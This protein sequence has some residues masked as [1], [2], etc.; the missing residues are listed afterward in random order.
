VY[1]RESENIIGIILSNDV[2]AK[3]LKKEGE[4]RLKEIMHEPIFI[5]ATRK[6]HEIFYLF[7]NEKLNISIVLDEYGGLAGIVTRE[8]IIEEVLGELYDEN[9]IQGIDRIQ[10][11]GAKSWRIMG[12]TSLHQFSDMFETVIPETEYAGTIA[13]YIVEKLDRIPMPGDEI[14]LGNLNLRIEKTEK[15][16]IVSIVLD[17]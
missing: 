9:E 11:L 10:K 13:G 8:D 7:K 14:R 12:D 2:I 3:L 15:N 17:M 5:P 1:E 4:L 6:L 16:R